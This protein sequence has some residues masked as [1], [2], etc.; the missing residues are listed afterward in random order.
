MLNLT[1]FT[2]TYALDKEM[3]ERLNDLAKRWEKTGHEMTPEE[4]FSFIMTTSS[5]DDIKQRMDMI[6]RFLERQGV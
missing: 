1:N 6:S 3:V 5:Y 2:V 4:M